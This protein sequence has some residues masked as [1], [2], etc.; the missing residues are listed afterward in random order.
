MVPNRATHHICADVPL[1]PY[2]NVSDDTSWMC[3]YWDYGPSKDNLQKNFTWSIFEYFG[4]PCITPHPTLLGHYVFIYSPNLILYSPYF[5]KLVCHLLLLHLHL[6]ADFESPAN[7]NIGLGVVSCYNFE[8]F[9]KF[10][11]FPVSLDIGLQN[12]DIFWEAPCC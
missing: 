8:Q 10:G 11:K 4:S 12:E 3:L 2:F 5:D 9:W 1:P 7:F 6:L